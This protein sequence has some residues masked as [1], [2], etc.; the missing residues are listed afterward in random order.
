MMAG[1]TLRSADRITAGEGN[2]VHQLRAAM[3]ETTDQAKNSCL[4]AMEAVQHYN[5]KLFEFAK[6][7]N[8]AALNYVQEL[9]DVRSPLEFI[10]I[11]TRHAAAQIEVSVEQAKELGRL[12]RELPPN[13]QSYSRGDVRSPEWL[14][15]EPTRL[16]NRKPRSKSLIRDRDLPDDHRYAK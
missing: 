11:T 1:S 7:N 12:V 8:N 10:Q 5:A 4:M 15:L 2:A 13:L 3:D 16:T 14:I 9:A 6:T